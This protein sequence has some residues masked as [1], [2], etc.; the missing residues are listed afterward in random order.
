M[1]FALARFTRFT[2]LYVIAVNIHGYDFSRPRTINVRFRKSRDILS[3]SRATRRYYE[4]K[5]KKYRFVSKKKKTT[6]FRNF[7]IF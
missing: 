1:N 2:L 7:R 4:T 6:N 3:G 5:F